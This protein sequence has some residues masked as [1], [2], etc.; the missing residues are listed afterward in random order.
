MFASPPLRQAVNR[1]GLPR[2][3]G[4]ASRRR[5]PYIRPRQADPG[6]PPTG[7]GLL[8]LPMQL[9]RASI[10]RRL[11][12]TSPRGR[13]LRAKVACTSQDL[14]AVHHDYAHADAQGEHPQEA[15]YAVYQTPPAP[16]I[17]L[18]RWHT[19]SRYAAYL[20][21]Y[22]LTWQGSSTRHSPMSVDPSAAA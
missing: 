13:R 4:V 16:R 8:R 20:P 18:H 3:P 1:I 19:A 7:L 12:T 6:T 21:P 22:L 11:A 15:H 2:H 9:H 14:S 17:G 10:H 5:H